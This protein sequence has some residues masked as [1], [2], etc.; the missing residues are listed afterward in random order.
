MAWVSRIPLFNLSKGDMEEKK[1]KEKKL[2]EYDVRLGE[3][4]YR[5]LLELARDR[6]G[7][8]IEYGQL[9]ARAKADFPDDELAQGATAV[10]IGRRLLVIEMFCTKHGLPNLACLVVNK[11][12]QPGISYRRNWEEDKRRVAEYDWQSC[13]QAWVVHIDELRKAAQKLPKRV[14]RSREEAVK[15]FMEHW[16][17]D[18]ASENPKHP[19]R[20]D[21][22]P[23]EAIIV[24]L[25]GGYSPEE[26]FEIGLSNG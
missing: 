22:K 11:R 1:T 9:V 12:G 4:Y 15:L 7:A 3:I 23:K 16:K 19:N 8:T 20:I 2:T 6:P 10:G 13:E 21:N 25:K 18:A 5:Y 26:A 17:A 24:A 14:R